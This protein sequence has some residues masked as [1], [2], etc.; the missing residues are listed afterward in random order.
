VCVFCA[1][2]AATPPAVSSVRTAGFCLTGRRQRERYDTS[3]DV[4]AKG[5]QNPLRVLKVLF[6]GGTGIISSACT[7]LAV[8]QGI[9]LFLL[10]RGEST[11]PVPAGV[12]RL[13]ADIRDSDLSARALGDHFDSVV[14][15]VGFTPEH[16]RSDR[17]LFRDRTRQYVF[18][19]SASAYATLPRLR[20][21]FARRRG[22]HRLLRRGSSRRLCLR[23]PAGG[24]DLGDGPSQ[25]R[26]SISEKLV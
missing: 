9:E 13:S 5:A 25:K 20:S 15:F 16:V 4:R 26:V 23:C 12:C 8:E 14:R 21:R 3:D 22:N 24:A 1:P 6:I 10:T 7:R 11:R 18:I 19:S 2:F 17:A